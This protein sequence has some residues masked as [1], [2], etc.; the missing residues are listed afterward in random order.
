MTRKRLLFGG[1]VIAVAIIAVVIFLVWWFVIRGDSPPPVS[2]EGAASSLE[3]EGTAEPTEA[4]T[5]EAATTE[6]AATEAA[7]P[8]SD[9]AGDAG[10][11]GSIDGMW[12][13]SEQGESFGGYRVEEEL[14]SIGYKEAVGRTNTLEA[15]MTITDGQL[16][17]VN[18][19]ADMRDLRSDSSF[20]DGYLRG[21]S[22]ESDT[23]P[24]ATFELSEPVAVP[25]GLAAG[26]AV[27]LEANGMLTLHGVT[28]AVT[29]PLEARR[30][31]ALIL[32]VGQIPILFADYDIE[33]PRSPRVVSVEDNGVMEWQLVLERAP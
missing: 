23:F 30:D 10:D 11:A 25:E 33:Q 12:V 22:I 29:V 3:G 32:V 7:A 13:L 26:E 19:T 14:V 20:R 16:T 27:S 28:R 24:Y 15:S 5:T 9:D 4:A 1:G 17:A 6:A 8:A 31:G 21:Q 2:L 18:V